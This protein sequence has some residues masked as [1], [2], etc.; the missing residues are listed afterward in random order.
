MRAVVLTLSDSGYAGTRQ[1]RSG[2]IIMEFLQ[3]EGYEVI[4]TAVLPDGKE[5]LMEELCKWSDSNAADL[6]LTTG[7]TGFSPRDLTPEA[8]NAVI[9]RPAPGITEAIRLKSLQST[10]HAMLSR[11]TAGIRKEC[12]IINMPGSPKAVK[13]SLEILS[14]AVTHGLAVLKGMAKECASE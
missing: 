3:K 13:E 14:P 7:G 2:P 5:P 10:S 9:E 4:H 8:T 11:A 1:D 12:L 6:I